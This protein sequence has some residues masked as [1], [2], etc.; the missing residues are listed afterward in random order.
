MQ[1]AKGTAHTKLWRKPFDHEQKAAKPGKVVIDRER[2][3]GCGYCV[4]FCPKEALKMSD[5]LGPRGYTIAKVADQSK[6]L[7]C[8]LCEII[9]PEFAINL[10]P[11]DDKK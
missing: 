8:G 1:S 4:E 6:C 9:C 5:E 11:G 3:K 7:S 2:C 10:E